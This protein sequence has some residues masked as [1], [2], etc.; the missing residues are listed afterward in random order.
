MDRHLRILRR[1]GEDIFVVDWTSLAPLSK[2]RDHDLL[3]GLLE[4]NDEL[5]FFI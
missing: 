5:V 2:I 1:F 4:W 3:I